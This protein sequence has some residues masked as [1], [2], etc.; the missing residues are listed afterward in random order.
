VEDSDFFASI[1]GD[2]FWDRR[3]AKDCKLA[4]VSDFVRKFKKNHS[5]DADTITEVQ[6]VLSLACPPTAGVVAAS[7]TGGCVQGRH[8]VPAASTSSAAPAAARTREPTS[9]DGGRDGYESKEY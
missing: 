9:N 3:Q 1:A 5:D 4:D 2:P 8:S 7:R 6:R